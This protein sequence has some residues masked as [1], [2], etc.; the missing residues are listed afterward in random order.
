MQI[1]EDLRTLAADIFSGRISTDQLPP[2]DFAEGIIYSLPQILGPI[3]IPH[4]DFDDDA[5]S[6]TTKR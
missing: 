5:S 6:G 2:P 3:D 1:A 4:F